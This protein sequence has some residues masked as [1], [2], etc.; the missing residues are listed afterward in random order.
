MVVAIVI[1]AVLVLLLLVMR[2][3][4]KRDRAKGHVNRGIGEIRSSVRN[5]R[6]NMLGRRHGGARAGMPTPQE[7]ARKRDRFHRR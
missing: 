1:G 2:W 6:L 7:Y 5:E 3:A 4:D